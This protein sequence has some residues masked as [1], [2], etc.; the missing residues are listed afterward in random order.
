MPKVF[1]FP[2]PKTLG[3][4]LNMDISPG[5]RSRM[6]KIPAIVL[7]KAKHTL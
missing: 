2:V 7:I 3:L 5:F 1:F 4:V 6:N